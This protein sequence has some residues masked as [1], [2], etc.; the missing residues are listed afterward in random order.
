V[1][2]L[3]F[4]K[5]GL[6]VVQSATRKGLLIDGLVTMKEPPTAL[7]KKNF[8]FFSIRNVSKPNRISSSA[9][10]LPHLSLTQGVALNPGGSKD[11][12]FLGFRIYKQTKTANLKAD[13]RLAPR[14]AMPPSGA[15]GTAGAEEEQI[16]RYWK[17]RRRMPK[18]KKDN[19]NPWETLDLS[20]HLIRRWIF[21][22]FTVIL[23]SSAPVVI[24]PLVK[25]R[26]WASKLSGAHI[27]GVNTMRAAV[28]ENYGAPNE[29]LQVVDDAPMP[30]FTHHEVVVKVHASSVNPV[31]L[32]KM[33]GLFELVEQFTGDLPSTPGLDI[34]GTVVAVGERCSR[35]KVRTQTRTTA[36]DP[37][38]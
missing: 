19:A 1:F 2:H 15:R 30:L 4:L 21:I 5:P 9:V 16:E 35:I 20:L 36:E 14:Q 7:I 33:N 6:P 27:L 11:K 37:V 24:L 34:A 26:A 3:N 8:D 31:D 29:V 25:N 22:I 10:L 12:T 13:M 18:S 32:K 17:E 38:D 23:L 28:Y